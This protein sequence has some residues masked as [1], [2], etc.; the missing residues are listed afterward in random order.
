[1][2]IR[3][4]YGRPTNLTFIANFPPDLRG[5]KL[6]NETA[7]FGTGVRPAIFAILKQREKLL[8]ISGRVEDLPTIIAPRDY[9]MP[10]HPRLL[11]AL[12]WP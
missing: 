9:V 4:V 8:V 1:M 3:F 12:S 10:N 11:R 6:Q 5:A 7:G 2:M